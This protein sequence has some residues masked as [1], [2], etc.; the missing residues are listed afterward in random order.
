MWEENGSPGVNPRVGE[1]AHSM[2][3]AS[4]VRIEPRSL[5]CEATTLPAAP[6]CHPVRHYSK[7]LIMWHVQNFGGTGLA[8]FLELVDVIQFNT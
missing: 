7:T 3:A 4:K 5:H 6:L 2:H 8:G 1:C